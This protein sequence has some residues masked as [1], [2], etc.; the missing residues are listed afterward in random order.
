MIEVYVLLTLGALG[1]LLNKSSNEIKQGK[2]DIVNVNEVPSMRNI[3]ES[4]HS[5]KTDAMYREK[6]HKKFEESKDPKKTG[7][8]SQNYHFLK[9]VKAEEKEDDIV[10][11]LSGEYISKK[12]FVHNN[13]VP[14]YGGSI[15]QS[16]DDKS[17]RVL[18]ENF[19]GI[20][21]LQKNKCE[22]ASFYD[23]TK[24]VTNVNGMKSQDD[25]YKDRIV[26]PTIRNN[27]F[28]IPQ[29]KVGPGLGQ[30]YNSAPAGGFQQF[31]IQQY[32]QDK[33]V[34]ELRT[35]INPDK[36]ALG[37]VDRSKTTYDG[38]T[39]DGL[40]TGLRGKMGDF[41]KNRVETWYEQTPDMWFK[42]TGANTKPG[43]AG[44]FNVK[45]TNRL[46]TSKQHIGTAFGST[47]LARTADANVRVSARQQFKGPEM[48]GAAM[49][50]FGLG[51]KYDHGKSKIMVYNNE[52]DVTST[53]VYQGNLTSLI[54]AI[55]AP[56]EDMLKITKKQHTVDNPRHFGNM[57]VKIPKATVYDPSDVAKTT[58]KET[59]IHDAILGNLKGH[60]KI[61]V[62]D[63]DDVARTTVK[64]TT[65][66]DAILG[67][68][69]GH[70]KLTIYDPNDIARTTIKETLI[71]DE[72]GT[73]TLT[74]PKQIY[75]YDPD[76]VAKKTIRETLDRMDYEMNMAAKVYKGKVYDPNDPART[77]IKETTIDKERLFGNIDAAEGGGGYETNE[78][79]AKDTQ[80]QFLSDLDYYGGVGQ[81]RGEGYLTNEHDAKDT[82]KQFLSD[83]EYFGV[84]DSSDK[85]QK[86][87]DDMY[88]ANIT[89]AKEVTLFGR[90]PTQSGSKM[91]NDKVNMAV[92]KKQ[93]C[94]QRATRLQSN[95][96][97][98][99]NSIPFLEE[100]TITRTR[101]NFDTEM[102]NRLDISLLDAFREN[103][104]T[105]PLHSVA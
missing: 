95:K 15:K 6:A 25:F 81:D 28:P 102:N 70:E 77:T 13:M 92:P 73:G 68:L 58:I 31:D 80:K 37:M 4:K 57:N 88:N 41:S 74:G 87:Y 59:T 63:P 86:S 72:I 50:R 21:D 20:T 60:E 82:Q 26:A 61:T 52:R 83:I 67:N 93:E 45:E 44:K 24:D 38:R 43:K 3:Y 22:T 33:C 36:N 39:V 30:G 17:N 78:F 103:P 11:S 23:L 34:D 53:R 97:K 56:I 16:M 104:Y 12:E 27:E 29:T 19:T 54:K 85:K 90:A 69:K 89:E 49:S 62:H 65:I 14:F 64:E 84:A 105:Q 91:F 48:G 98:V 5:L 7:V 55:V 66:H 18:L 75:V 47:R 99:Y 96:D 100:D 94:D 9:D 76:E 79:D 1:Y 71:H 40:K 8:I 35:K 42:T 46:T 32:A 2:R 51:N 10:Q 101:K